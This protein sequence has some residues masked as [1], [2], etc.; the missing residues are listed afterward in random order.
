P[1][2][3]RH[4]FWCAAM[5]MFVPSSSEVFGVSLY[6]GWWGSLLAFLPLFWRDTPKVAARSALLVIGGLSTPVAI[7]LLPL[8]AGRLYLYRRRSELWIVVLCA[9][10]AAVQAAALLQ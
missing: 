10:L 8:Y 5:V 7:G 3:L 2:V 4:R 1:T 9:V 6:T